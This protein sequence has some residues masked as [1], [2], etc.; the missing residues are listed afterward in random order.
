MTDRE[1]SE[2]VEGLALPDRVIALASDGRR[3]S[4]VRAVQRSHA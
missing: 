3:G 1:V 2:S 4:L